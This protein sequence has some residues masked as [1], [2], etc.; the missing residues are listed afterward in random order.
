VLERRRWV[1]EDVNLKEDTVAI[2]G[3]VHGNDPAFVWSLRYFE[4]VFELG[5]IPELCG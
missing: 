5:K 2:L 3:V 4:V 1:V